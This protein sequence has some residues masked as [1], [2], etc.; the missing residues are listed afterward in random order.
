MADEQ[1]ISA[2]GGSASGGEDLQKQCDEYLNGWKRAKADLMNL[3]NDSARERTEWIQFASARSLDRLLPV[4]D[5]LRAAYEHDP[6]LVDVIRKLDDYLRGEGITE[7]P[8]EGK[9][10]HSFHEVIGR[11]KKEGAESGTIIVVAQRGY[12]L[13]EKILRPAKVIVAE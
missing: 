6:K 4:V 2:E 9:Y 7:I 3:Q 13:Q 1:T 8:T 11:E 5:T 10:D 12:K